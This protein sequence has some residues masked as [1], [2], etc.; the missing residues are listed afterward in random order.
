MLTIKLYDVLGSE[1]ETLVNEEKEAGNHE[2]DFDASEL[3]A[4]CT[5]ID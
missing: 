2:V 4:Q 5:S 1:I 3:Q